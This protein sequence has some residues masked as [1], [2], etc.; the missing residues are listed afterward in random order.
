MKGKKKDIKNLSILPI[1][2]ILV[3]VIGILAWMNVRHFRETI[4]SDIKQ[5]LLINA[6]LQAENIRNFFLGHKHG[7]KLLAGNP[8]IKRA[9]L[10]NESA[11]DL[12]RTDG[13]SC[14]QALYD[15]Y[16]EYY[17][18]GLYRLD[19]KG[20]V[21]SRVPFAKNRVGI[22]FS[23]KPGVKIV[24]ETH[25]PC[26][27]KV[28]SAFL[29]DKCFSV[30]YPVFEGEELI[31]II[32]TVVYLDKINRMVATIKL[33]EKGYALI[34]DDNG[35]ILAHPNVNFLLKDALTARK[36]IFPDRDWSDL[37]NII[38]KMRKGEEGTGS[39]YSAGW[40]EEKPILTQ[41]LTAFTPIRLDNEL[42][43]IG[44][45]MSYTEISASIHAYARNVIFVAG[46]FIVIVAGS[47][48]WF[49]KIQKEKG[50]FIAQTAENL[51][52]LNSQLQEEIT[53][54]KKTEQSLHETR[55][56]LE[57]LINCAS[58]PI[59]V[60][61][62][63]LKITI[64]NHAFEHLAGISA[65]E[66]IGR[67]LSI[68]FPE[69]TQ[70]QSLF[71]IERT[72]SGEYW[73]SVEIPILQKDGNVKI[74]LWNSANIYAEDGT[75]LVATVAQGMDITD[76]K[77]AEQ[78]RQRLNKE[79][80]AKNKELESILYAA[81]H[82][83]KS[84]LVNIQGFGYELSQSC[85]LIRSVLTSGGKDADMEKA[86]AV[87]LNEDI[88]DA[89]SFIM[90]STT[91][92]DSLLSGLLD[93]CR[94]K[95]VAMNVKAIDMNAVMVNVTASVEYQIKEAAA[96]V[97]IDPLPPC[98][99]DPSQ[100][101]RVFSNLLT[102]ALKFLDESRP[103]QIH[104]YGKSQNDKSIYCVEDNGRG[105]ASE[106]QEKIFQIFYQHEPD[107]K[108]GEGIGL[109]IVR[110]IVENHGGKVWVKSEVGKGS[111]FF[112]SLLCE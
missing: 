15:N 108:K 79:L 29:G 87:A 89:L 40:D 71:E 111:K 66:A 23:D 39:Y 70:T 91:K 33:I 76:R 64:F 10:N 8:C 67:T 30:C 12:L 77:L 112:V 83:L 2:C 6:K 41:K 51:R 49:Y 92:M 86:A 13:Y 99:G 106:H 43:S 7:L 34:L 107:T 22:D 102:N 27:S 95:T 104:V 105:I 65:D 59:I 62:P 109:T 103:G 42:W 31:G 84:P 45:N 55:D 48:S 11:Q 68:L 19:A 93:V 24:L 110:R 96:K 80:E 47:G 46:L 25:E 63:D 37:E 9:I 85:D 61:D 1:A 100:I 60:W 20:I 98:L 74:A 16:L 44:I 5:Q 35:T 18:N 3:I 52:I 73:E 82:D 75:T 88:P 14:E 78:T 94:L 50:I 72:L 69:Q 4:T 38:A 101:D 28:F 81:S 97:D 54:H 53:G 26:V 90:A 57:N 36:E 21:Q 58:A 56:Y 17:V 32:R